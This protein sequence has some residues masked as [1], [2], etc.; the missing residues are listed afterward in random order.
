[1]MQS[2]LAARHELVQ[3]TNTSGIF[4][5]NLQRPEGKGSPPVSKDGDILGHIMGKP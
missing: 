3:N 1:M 5:P 4:T 2:M